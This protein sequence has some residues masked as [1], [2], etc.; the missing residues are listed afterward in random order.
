MTVN[1]DDAA[2]VRII[3]DKYVNEGY[4][5]QRIAT[6]LNECGYRART[7]KMWHYANIR[8]ILCTRPTPAS[9]EA[10]KAVLRLCYIYRL[11]VPRYMRK[12]RIFVFQELTQPKKI[13]LPLLTPEG[14]HFL[15]VTYFVA[16]A[17][18]V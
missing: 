4:G 10:V 14:N 6:Y 15:Q 9:Y 11:L 17:A 2:V 13:V 18:H 8:G 5:A 12:C 3:F 7:G 1:E 16:I